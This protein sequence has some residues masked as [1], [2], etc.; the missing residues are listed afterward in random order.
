MVGY[1]VVYLGFGVT[2]WYSRENKK[3]IQ[4]WVIN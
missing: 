1:T 3:N 2:V 4:K